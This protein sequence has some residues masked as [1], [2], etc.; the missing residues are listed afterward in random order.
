MTM[1]VLS[2]VD[3]RH[4][5]ALRAVAETGSF[6]RAASRLGFTQS[7][8]SQQIA[9][10]ERALGAPV[11]DRPGGPKPV[12]LTPV[13]RVLAQHAET[14]LR[15]VDA[16]ADE[17][18]AVLAGRSGR[19]VIGSYQSVSVRVLPT[20]LGRL[21]AELPGI[22]LRVVEDDDKDRL[23]DLVAQGELDLTFTVDAVDERAFELI[24]LMHD[25]FV[26]LSP[27]DAHDPSTT[28]SL[29]SLTGA[30]LI[31]Q[32]PSSCQAQ[33]D[34]GLRANGVEPRY[35]FRSNDNTAV[36]AM[37]RA[38]MGNAVMPRLC[39]DPSDT[40]VVVRTTEPRLPDRAI[41]LA[42]ARGR[43]RPASLA[44]FVEL[45]REV[46]AAVLEPAGVPA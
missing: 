11:F 2:G 29:Q 21:R 24:P 23:L 7:A 40:G 25:D 33:I 15:Q 39:V 46:C 30:P 12:E 10:L 41:G 35:V 31:G 1:N 5:A 28:V 22:E 8:V 14:I 27:A 9:T 37:V 6:G 18:A 16:A 13:G 36:Q 4:L 17:L 42:L 19:L 26:V 34:N 3:L 44:R 43:T 38:G 32:N 45:T 20:V